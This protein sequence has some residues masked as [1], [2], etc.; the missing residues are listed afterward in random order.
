MPRKKY[1]PCPRCGEKK[2]TEL[3]QEA[4]P[5]VLKYLHDSHVI[6]QPF[7]EYR[8][9]A[10]HSCGWVATTRWDAENYATSVYH[11]MQLFLAPVE[12]VK[13]SEIKS[14]VVTETPPIEYDE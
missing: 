6:H 14:V 10:C 5:D 12:D 2:V 9:W 1:E 7:S 4:H 13:K 11:H 3:D 8:V